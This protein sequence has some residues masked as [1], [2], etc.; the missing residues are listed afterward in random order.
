MVPTTLK[1]PRTQRRWRRAG[2][3]CEP[4]TRPRPC[5]QTAGPGRKAGGSPCCCVCPSPCPK[6]GSAWPRGP[7]RWAARPWRGPPGSATDSPNSP[8][9][10][11]GCRRPTS[12][13]PRRSAPPC[14][15]GRSTAGCPT[16]C[17]SRPPAWAPEPS[18][19][20]PRSAATSSAAPCAVCCPRHWSWTPGP[21]CWNRTAGTR[22][23]WPKWWPSARC[24]SP[25]AGARRSPARTASSPP[26]RAARRPWS[27]PAPC[28][29]A[30]APRRASGSP[31]GTATTCSTPRSPRAAARRRPSVCCAS[32]GSTACPPP[33]GPS[34]GPRCSACSRAAEAPRRDPPRGSVLQRQ[35]GR[36][37]QG[38][39]VVARRVPQLVQ[40]PV[41]GV[42]HG[43][44]RRRQQPQQ[45]PE[46][47]V[48]RV[49]AGL[50]QPVGVEHQLVAGAQ[51]VRGGLEGHPADAQ[52]SAGG[53]VQ[54]ARRPAGGDQDGRQMTGGGHLQAVPAGIVHRVHTRGDVGVQA[55]GDP[56]EVGE[57]PR[58]IEIEVGQCGGGGAQPSHGGRGRDA[59]AHDVAHRERG[60]V[61]LQRD[62]VVP[63]AADLAQ[64]LRGPV[65]CGHLQARVAGRKPRQQAALQGLGGA[66][67]VV[68]EYGVVDAQRGARGEFAGQG[69]VVL[70]EGC[71]VAGAG[72]AHDADALAAGDQRDGDVGVHPGLGEQPGG[73]G[74]GGDP[75]HLA[76]LQVGDQ[77]R[78]AVADALGRRMVRVVD[79]EPAGRHERP[80]GVGRVGGLHRERAEQ[81]RPLV[82]VRAGGAQHAVQQVH[83]D[84]VG[85]LGHQDVGQLARRPLHL[86]GGADAGRAGGHQPQPP[87]GPFDLPGG[88]VPV[89]VVHRHRGDAQGVPL[90][91]LQP[92]QRYRPRVVV[93]R[94]GGGAAHHLPVHHRHTGLQHL[95]HG[96]LDRPE[97]SSGQHLVEALADVVGLGDAVHGRQGRVD[98][99]VA[100][101]RVE[102]GQPDRGLREQAGGQGRIALHPAQ[103]A[104]VGGQPERVVVAEVVREPHVA[105]LDRSGAAVLV[106]DG[107]RPRPAPAG[108]HHLTEQ[109]QGRLAV[110]GAQQQRRRVLPDR[111]R[112]GVAEQL[113]GL[114]TPHVDPAVRFQQHRG[115]AQ[116]IHQPGRLRGTLRAGFLPVGPPRPS[117]HRAPSFRLLPRSVGPL[118]DRGLTYV[119][120]LPAPEVRSDL[121]GVS[122]PGPRRPVPGRGRRGRSGTD[123]P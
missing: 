119:K 92:V 36:D 95:A 67:G 13:G 85:Q 49:V 110:L 31:Y 77:Q 112:A 58:R 91:V 41:T 65:P 68:V 115:D 123:R 1:S 15:S 103:G 107:E 70:V 9:P 40:Q 6:R 53:Q 14:C 116:Q 76:A 24:C 88:P 2:C 3:P 105:E 22:R 100:Q 120:R 121:G 32:P 64:R 86:Q 98:D 55:E 29:P 50:H 43:A 90:V 5:E 104:P 111:L 80:D 57:D 109:V 4:C 94:V 62:D 19:A 118:P 74:I 61:A 102:D 16:C 59:A 48:D 60:A 8:C 27:W 93:V 17:A 87:L 66:A 89:G 71:G 11:G 21:L 33:R 81:R 30:T 23:T 44:V 101:R 117:A 35:H 83:R 51:V 7:S 47:G 12:S 108:L 69:E 96:G 34:S 84:H 38:D 37:E 10:Y 54:Q 79:G 45:L 106:P 97:R 99:D 25:C 39:V 18:A 42:L 82:R 73:V 72:Q 56:V 78:T 28:T 114:R 46:P 122:A 52:R 20:P 113:L 26:R 75:A 63:V